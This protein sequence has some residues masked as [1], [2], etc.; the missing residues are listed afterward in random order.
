M[1]RIGL[2]AGEAS[3]DLLGAGLL[4]E[5]KSMHGDIVVEGI[6]GE[7]LISEGM[8][9]HCPMD[10]LS[11]MGITE[12][13]AHYRELKTIQNNLIN[14]FVNNPPD[15]FIGIDAPDF[16][17]TIENKL[18][19]A[20][21]KTIHYVSPSVW[22]W[23]SY[24]IRKI[25]KAIN[26][27][28][29]LFPFENEIYEQHNVP[30]S[31]VGHPLADK[32]HNNIDIQGARK[33]LGLSETKKVIALLPG[34]RTNEIKTLGPV[35]IQ[36]AKQLQNENGNLKFISGLAN[37]KTYEQFNI[38]CKENNFESDIRL[39]IG[40][41]HD[42]LAA[43][44]LI[45]IASG[46]ATLEA[47]LLQKP[48][49]VAYRLSWLTY[50]IVKILAKIKYA[51]LPNILAGKELVA[52]CLQDDCNVF[53]IKNEMQVLLDNEEQVAHIKRSFSGLSSSLAIGANKRAAKAVS[54][55]LHVR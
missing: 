15:I 7:Q 36:V 45:L 39:F 22:A 53:R 4:K 28:L 23:R 2:V 34:S 52:E 18:K 12:V 29:T 6:G 9:S 54:E 33:K 30:V 1:F 11:I 48:M 35:F 44:D 3:G 42:V 26:L 27:M 55:L 10:K 31:H 21:I 32:L 49:V 37:Q 13:V 46:T 47:M 38:L 51:S 20:G 19:S 25:K 24:R 8:N 40:Q 50:C 5:L 43:A 17:L 14:Y 41:T 16:N